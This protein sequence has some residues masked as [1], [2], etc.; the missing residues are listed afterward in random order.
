MNSNAMDF[1]VKLIR[2][3]RCRLIIDKQKPV[4][5]LSAFIK[6]YSIQLLQ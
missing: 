4:E 5:I 3:I 6:A 1:D 2:L